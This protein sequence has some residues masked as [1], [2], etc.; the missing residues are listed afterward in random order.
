MATVDDGQSTYIN[1][2]SSPLKDEHVRLV[3]RVLLDFLCLPHALSFK[4]SP[5]SLTCSPLKKWMQKEDDP[6]LVGPGIFSGA[7][8]V[9]LSVGTH[10]I[11]STK[12]G[13]DVVVDSVIGGIK[14]S[15]N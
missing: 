11:C 10:W 8:A 6:F 7:F 5:L 15:K 1:N 2:Q 3:I 13:G 14:G 4:Y 12:G 9:K